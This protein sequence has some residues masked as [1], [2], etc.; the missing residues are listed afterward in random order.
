[1]LLTSIRSYIRVDWTLT[2]L[3]QKNSTSALERTRNP[4]ITEVN[5]FNWG[6]VYPEAMQCILPITNCFTETKPS[7]IHNI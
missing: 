2:A 3:D 4:H 6:L 7:D 1:M 5:A